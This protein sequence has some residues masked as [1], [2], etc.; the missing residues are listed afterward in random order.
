MGVEFI[1][2]FIYWY[3]LGE[4]GVAHKNSVVYFTFSGKVCNYTN[5]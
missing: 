1:Y 5:I 3:K 2:L 4:R